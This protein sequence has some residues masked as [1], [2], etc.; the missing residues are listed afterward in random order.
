[1]HGCKRTHEGDESEPI[2][3]TIQE[4]LNQER[5]G[6]TSDAGARVHDTAGE[7]AAGAEPL[8]EE[9]RGRHIVDSCA[10]RVNHAKSENEMPWLAA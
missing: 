10:Y 5:E 6:S 7:P 8:E 1:M 3:G 4:R 2:A 9:R